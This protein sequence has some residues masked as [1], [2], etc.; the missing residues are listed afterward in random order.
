MRGMKI[1][2]YPGKSADQESDE[3]CIDPA[4]S[5]GVRFPP[6]KPFRTYL[7]VR[8]IQGRPSRQGVL[9]KGY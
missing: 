7:W 5:S 8:H 3:M 9:Q 6:F 4:H 1:I 2:A